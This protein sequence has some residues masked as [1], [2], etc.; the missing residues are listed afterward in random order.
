MLYLVNQ[1]TN[2]VIMKYLLLAVLFSLHITNVNAQSITGRW[3][4]NSPIVSDEGDDN[5]QFFSDGTFCYNTDGEGKLMR[6]AKFGGTYKVNSTN[7]I[8]TPTYYVEEVGGYLTR[9]GAEPGTAEWAFV[10]SKENKVRLE[11]IIKQKL[12]FKI[13]SIKNTIVMEIDSN[14]FYKIQNDPAKYH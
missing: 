8:L 3:Q 1:K 14:K 11:Q 10:D 13:Y 7:I 4:A 12:P 6:I 9:T 2:Q 5:Y